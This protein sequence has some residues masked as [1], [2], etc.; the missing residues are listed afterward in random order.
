MNTNKYTTGFNVFLGIL[1]I[2]T[3]GIGLV[4]FALLSCMLDY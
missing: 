1:F 3:F 4:I 2:A